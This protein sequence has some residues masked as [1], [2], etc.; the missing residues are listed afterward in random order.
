MGGQGAE[1]ITHVVL[2]V[3]ENRSYGELIGSSTAPYINHL[4]AVCGLA[5]NYFAVA[6]PSLPNYLALT[7]GSTQGVTDDAGP[8][9]HPISG[10]SIF[11]LLGSGWTSLEES[12]PANC[13]LQS[14]GEYA[15]K[16]N[17][18]AYYTGVRSACAHQDVPLGNPPNL[19][20]AFTLI[21][22]NL[23][24][25]MHDCATSAGDSWLARE[26]PLLLATPQYLSRQTAI[27]ITW[28]ESTGATQQVPALVIAPTV[29]AGSRVATQFTHYSLLRSIEEL[30]GLSP[31]LGG[32][33]S[34]TSMVGG[35]NL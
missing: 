6:H 12:M 29:P 7:S 15:V 19:S 11:G 24:D 20:A 35:F 3:M 21:T 4:A 23:C 27:F 13:D 14:G 16:H 26:V 9:A 32:A 31:L 10:H 2:I 34:A 1:T 33:A 30:L 22:P 5:T 17:P 28:D 18:A 8:Y 25:D